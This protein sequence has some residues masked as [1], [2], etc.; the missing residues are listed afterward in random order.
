MRKAFN[1]AALDRV[2]I[3]GLQH[4]RNAAARTDHGLQRGFGT[5]GNDQIDGE[6]GRSVD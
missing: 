5:L 2:V 6:A 4:N 1:I 3:D